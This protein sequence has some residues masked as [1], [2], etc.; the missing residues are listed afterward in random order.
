M[1]VLL[2]KLIVAC[3]KLV[4]ALW[5]M[6]GGTCLGYRRYDSTRGCRMRRRIAGISGRRISLALLAGAV[7]LPGALLAPAG[8]ARAQDVVVTSR[9]CSIEATR[10]PVPGPA[11]LVGRAEIGRLPADAVYWHIDTFPDIASANAA[12]GSNG[13]VVT[14][15]G[16]VWLFT[17]AGKAWRAKGGAHVAAIGPLPVQPAD[18]FVAEYVHSMFSPGD[19]A[20]IHRH[21]GPE[22]F[23]ALD[24]DTCLE[25]PHGVLT[26]KGPGNTLIMP[27]GEPMLL[28][29][30][31]SVPRRAFAL[32]LHDATLP[33]TTRVGTWKP[34]GL[35]KPFEPGV[36]STAAADVRLAISPD[37]RQMLWGSIGRDGPAEQQDIWERHRV[38]DGWSVPARV[39]FDTGAVEF[40]PA[41]SADGTRVFF[42]SDR[43]GGFGGTDIYVVTRD[44]ASFAFGI[45]VN[46]GSKI[47]S[48]GDEWA[49]T[50]TRDGG[51]LFSSD[52]WGG[53]GHH[54][55]FLAARG[56]ARPINLG[57]SI[58]SAAEDFDAA[59]SP[60]GM[61]MVFVSGVM[62][63]DKAATGLYMSHNN[64]GVW[65]P[66]Q[67]LP[68]G[69]SDF[70]IGPS[71]D[72][73]DGSMLAYSANC[74]GGQGRM[75][76]HRVP[77]TSPWIPAGL[78]K[79]DVTLRQAPATV[80]AATQRL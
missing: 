54:D 71:F 19:S 78:H 50:P 18:A 34:K 28:M 58:N 35:C 7:L 20:P 48:K 60:D 49:P 23:Y 73:A 40:D 57:A 51:L 52:G 80:D 67:P 68:V 77:M 1:V 63:D 25:M 16:K 72:P 76:I 47:N 65:S 56:S 13:T 2:A 44:P 6:A 55:L 17:I 70:V 43:A 14:D 39:T 11:C 31:G 74:A 75:D 64:Q 62:T 3:G 21:S 26:G 27:A 30:A 29:A 53:L 69:C 42:H 33:A 9:P 4:A 45:P 22:A 8:Q 12:R 37:G 38:D 79:V 66:R 61:T 41:F 10:D 5:L 46:A 15:F 36:V 24:G 32:V 59:L